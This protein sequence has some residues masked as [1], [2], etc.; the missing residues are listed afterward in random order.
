M[1]RPFAFT[2]R[3]ADNICSVNHTHLHTQTVPIPRAPAR[4]RSG[5]GIHFVRSW[6]S[7]EH[8]K[9]QPVSLQLLCAGIAR[10]S[11]ASQAHVLG[12]GAAGVGACVETEL[13]TEGKAGIPAV[14]V[15]LAEAIAEPVA[16]ACA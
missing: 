2:S 9:V 6:V 1:K 13:S 7:R 8:S 11:V 15:A 14:V 5:S 10:V 12:R 3:N 16:R 4:V